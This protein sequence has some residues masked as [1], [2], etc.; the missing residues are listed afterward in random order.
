VQPQIIQLAENQLR[1]YID[2]DALVRAQSQAMKD[3]Q[4]VRGSMIWRELRGVRYLIRTSPTSAQRSIGPDS[5]ETQEMYQRFMQRKEASKSRVKSLAQ[6]MLEQT[7]LNRVYRVGRTPNVVVKVL[8][9][10][11]KAGITEQFLAVGTHAIYAYESACGVQV[12]A[13]AMA[14][15]DLDLLF[16][17]RKR[18]TFVSAMQRLDSSLVSVLRKADPSF[19]VLPHQLQ[20]AVNDDGF[21][22]D[23]IRRVA[24]EKDPHPLPMTPS[25][26]DL[27]AVQVGSG[28]RMLSARKFEQ[29]VVATNGQMAT[30]R[31]LHP[32][33]FVHIKTKLAK[34][35]TRDPLKRP[36]DAL[37]AKT[38][39]YLWD[40]YLSSREQA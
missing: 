30:M 14:T 38:V 21:E 37:Q 17:T 25:E 2:A 32:L 3:A 24:K 5:P 4:Q 6:R 11:E 10:L 23:I 1:Q 31:T 12:S 8:Q 34:D 27:W 22:V 7:K 29:L 28:E 15:R 39:K 20:T 13:D 18:M 26:D 16:D 9:A 19:R 36:K 33:D 35:R 40:E